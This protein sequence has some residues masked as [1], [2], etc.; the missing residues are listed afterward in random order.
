MED[1]HGD[2]YEVELTREELDDLKCQE[3]DLRN[4]AEWCEEHKL[5]ELK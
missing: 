2:E 4:D 5:G 1:W 3:A